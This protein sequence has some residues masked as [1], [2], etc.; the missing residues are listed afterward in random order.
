M[1]FI[2]IFLVTFG[3]KIQVFFISSFWSKALAVLGV[4]FL[5]YVMQIFGEPFTTDDLN[6]MEKRSMLYATVT[7]Y[8]G[9]YFVSGTLSLL[10]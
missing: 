7:L 4:C 3:T 9:I 6:N 5:S 2:S 8:A 10:S 1:V